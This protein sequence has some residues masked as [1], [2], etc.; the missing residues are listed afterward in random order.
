MKFLLTLALS[1]IT[2]GAMAA[3][4]TKSNVSTSDVYLQ[5]VPSKGCNLQLK[6][7]LPK[8]DDTLEQFL[9]GEVF[10]IQASFDQA[11]PL[12]Y[13]AFKKVK[14]EEL[15]N[16]TVGIINIAECYRITATDVICVKYNSAGMKS[17]ADVSGDKYVTYDFANKKVV[18]LSDI[19]NSAVFEALKSKGLNVDNATNIRIKND[20]LFINIGDVNLNIAVSK[21]YANMTDYALGLMGRTR[22]GFM[23]KTELP[24]VTKDDTNVTV[25]QYHGGEE[26]L[27]KYFA[28]NI[29][30]PKGH[31]LPG[32]GGGMGMPPMGMPGGN[33]QRG[34]MNNR[35]DVKYVVNTDG[36]IYSVCIEKGIDPY[37][38]AEAL[39]TVL[40]LEKFE[41]AKV[42]DTTVRFET[43]QPVV[44]MPRFGGFG[45]FRPF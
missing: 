28:E 22:E 15:K 42:G 2:F 20:S 32:M 16:I 10:G 39:K 41:P 29:Q 38:D 18:Q 33:P 13:K 34:Q 27:N 7:F 23:Q 36:S 6:F 9:G 26:A 25:A 12:Y 31:Q 43:I 11:I 45:G 30:F 5:T 17:P 3:D 19:V 14:K 37:F 24:I 44:F 21:F 40:G 8:L 1:L 4:E 35:V